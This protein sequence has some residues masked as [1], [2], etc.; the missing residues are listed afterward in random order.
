M[1][2]HRKHEAPAEPT[3]KKGSLSEGRA[4]LVGIELRRPAVFFGG[5]VTTRDAARKMYF[6]GERISDIART[7]GVTRQRIFNIVK[8]MDKPNKQEH[9]DAWREWLKTEGK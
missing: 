4:R 2:G 5:R 8:D 6:H 7:L 9:I 1:A 3:V